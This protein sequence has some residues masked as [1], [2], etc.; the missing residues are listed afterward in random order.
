V[1]DEGEKRGTNARGS[2]LGKLAEL[3]KLL[4]KLSLSG[5]LDHEEDPLLVVKVTVQPE[6]VGMST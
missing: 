3:V 4:V 5:K 6:D 1:E 2:L